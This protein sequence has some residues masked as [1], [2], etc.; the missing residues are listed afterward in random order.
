[1][2]RELL[3]SCAAIR[4]GG[5]RHRGLQRAPTTQSSSPGALS[6][7]A[8]AARASGTAVRSSRPARIPGVRAGTTRGWRSS[9]RGC[10]RPSGANTNGTPSA[11]GGRPASCGPSSAPR[12]APQ[13]R[14]ARVCAAAAGR[15]R[16]HGRRRHA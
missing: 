2:P 4:N 10:A 5:S 7:V 13:L 1:M 15:S 6:P 11:H 12:G 16:P 9:A 8:Y 14:R 3:M